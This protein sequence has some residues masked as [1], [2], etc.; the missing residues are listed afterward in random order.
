M[1]RVCLNL[2]ILINSHLEHVLD[3][4]LQE[5]DADGK[6]VPECASGSPLGPKLYQDAGAEKKSPCNRGGQTERV[7]T[8]LD[9]SQD[10]SQISG[11]DGK[12]SFTPLSQIG[13]RD[14]ASIGCGQQLTLLSIEVPEIVV[15]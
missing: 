12:S 3:Q 11:P 8:C 1:T 4:T 5:T 15:S 13:F 2:V 10:I 9:G 14:P 6:D 7:K